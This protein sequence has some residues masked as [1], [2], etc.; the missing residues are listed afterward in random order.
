MSL[1]TKIRGIIGN[2]FAFDGGDGPILKNNAGAIEHRNSA[3][4]AFAVAR[5]ATP[6]GADDLT[7]KAY[8]DSLAS[9]DVNMIEILFDFNDAGSTVD[10]TFAGIVG[11]RV[12]DARVDITTAF[13]ANTPID[14][15]DTGDPDRFAAAADIKEEKVD[16]YDF[17]QY[18]DTIASVFRVTVGASAATT[19]AGRVIITYAVPAV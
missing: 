5:G 16:V 15:G 12:L 2:I 4:S 18:T 8:V 13:D 11:G 6:V 1:Y 10:S 17:P 9:G 14:I 19:G 7:T 3:D